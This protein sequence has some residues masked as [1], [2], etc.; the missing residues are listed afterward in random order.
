[1]TAVVIGG[2]HNGLAAAFFLATAGMKPIVLE[3]RPTVGGGAITQEIHPG[4]RCPALSH[5]VSTF[6]T[7]IVKAMGLE[8][9]GLRLSREPGSVLALDEGRAI[10]LDGDRGRSPNSIRSLSARDADRWLPFTETMARVSEVVASLFESVPPDID[11]PSASDLW[12]L[13]QTG[14]KFRALGKRDAFTLLRWAPMPVADLV[15]EW[16][17]TELLC[18]AIAARGVSG[19]ALG[20]RSAGSSLLLLLSQA[21]R[22]TGIAAQV[23]GGPG[24]LTRAMAESAKAAGVEIHTSA[25][26]DRIL[27]DDGRAVGVRLENGT[28]I[29]A[30]LVVSAVDPRTTF[31]RLVDPLDLMPEFCGRVLHYRSAG[32]VAKINLALSAL[33]RFPAVRPEETSAFLAGRIHVG[34]T[35]DY[36]ERAFD[37]TKYGEYS[38]EPWLEIR[39]PSV[40]D[41][42]LAPAGAHVMS[43]YA[44]YAPY[45]LRG[46]SW[47]DARVDFRNRVMRVLARH[48]PDVE[49]LLVAEQVLLPEDLERDYG[50]SGGHMFHGEL[51]LDQLFTMRPI[52]GHANYT[53]PIAGLYLC[54]AGTHPGGVLSGQSGRL[55]ARAILG[56]R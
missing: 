49:R 45:R 39:I 30:S 11:Q 20:P 10:F 15:H 4:F 35:L 46:G 13:L 26:V 34:P 17:E 37:H 24:E 23:R 19:G 56:R 18:A 41:P 22:R 50:F 5:D 40:L 9:Y 54:G 27:V 52:L 29:R 7:D 42:T 36:L 44:H 3:R 48:A 33:P 2:G 12:A 21:H 32:N 25:P 8:R 47:A 31:L 1:M 55:A 6:R 16:F 38:E 28:E 14:R 53:T 43:L 51:T